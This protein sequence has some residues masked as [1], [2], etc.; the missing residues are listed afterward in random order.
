MLQTIV[1]LLSKSITIIITALLSVSYL[2][3]NSQ[4]ISADSIQ[5]DPITCDYSKIDSIAINFPKT[6]KFKEIEELS[7]ALTSNIETDHEKFRVLFRWVT[8]NIQYSSG[9]RSTNP[10]KIAKKKKA[11]CGG[12]SSLLDALC[13]YAGIET[14]T[15]SGN[16]KSLPE[17]IRDNPL[18][19]RH[20]WNAVKLYDKWYLVD[21]TWAAGGYDT[22]KHKFYKRYDNSWFL[23]KPEFFVLSHYPKEKKWQ[24]LSTYYPRRK[25]KKTPGSWSDVLY[26]GAYYMQHGKGKLKNDLKIRITTETEIEN[27]YLL[28]YSGIKAGNRYLLNYIKKEGGTYL[29]SYDFKNE[30]FDKKDKGACVVVINGEP[31]WNFWKL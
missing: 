19:S 14:V 8:E 21:A 10:K 9:S 5:I 1:Q 4:D 13:L 17:H 29:I 31:V 20:A 15:I 26:S 28:F 7:H 30:N 12:Y 25:F 23:S 2:N 27:C 24:L 3:C 18:R 22:K 6:F 16:A 11:V